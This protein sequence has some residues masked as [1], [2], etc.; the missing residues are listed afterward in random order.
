MALGKTEIE[1]EARITGKTVEY[2]EAERLMEADLADSQ[3]IFRGAGAS[4]S[5]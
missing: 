3:V 4:G 5:W 1:V 2:I